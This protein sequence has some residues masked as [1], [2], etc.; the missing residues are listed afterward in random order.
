MN[1]FAGIVGQDRATGALLRALETGRLS[2]SL[3][4]H[5]PPGVGKLTA[6]LALCRALLCRS[7][8]GPAC[9]ACPS[10]L[11]IDE[12]AL[13][14]PDV[15]VAFPEK[16]SDFEK[17]AQATEGA[18]G[19]DLQERQ[20][21]VI[22]NPAWT[23]LIDRIRQGI[24]FLQR[25]PSESPRSVWIVDQAHRLPAEAGNALLKTLEEP[26]PYAVLLLITTS[27]HAL[28]PTLRSRARAIPFQLVAR[29]DIAAYLQ[30]RKGVQ[31]EEAA[32]RA[33]LSGGRIGAAIG[34]DL[35]AYRERRE[36]ILRVLDTLVRRGDPGIAVARAEEIARGGEAVD[37]DLEI[38]LS[39]LRDV[40]IGGAVPPGRAPFIHV[41]LA[42]RL[43]SLSRLLA[44]RGPDAVRDLEGALDIIRK[45]G[46][47][48]LA[49]EHALI[50]LVPPPAPAL[51][52]GGA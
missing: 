34:L 27:Y 25:H 48:Q 46:N 29:A 33:G 10:C 50:G 47:R 37:G 6:A 38:L 9:G 13:R 31:G 19:V 14:H 52:R 44:A 11:R 15:R 4:F 16:L 32:L 23:L 36:Q 51:P 28:L 18:L 26:P 45:K 42:E 30:N 1:P 40:M 2:P 43:E 20:E 21:E 12:R 8:A 49:I 35:A 7:E 24:S 17:G 3:I 41:D 5:G 22:V 39:L